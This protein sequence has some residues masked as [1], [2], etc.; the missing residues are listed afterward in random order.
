MKLQSL[1][2]EELSLSYFTDADVAGI[3]NRH[4]LSNSV[5]M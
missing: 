3:Q 5:Q 4:V 1:N 2:A